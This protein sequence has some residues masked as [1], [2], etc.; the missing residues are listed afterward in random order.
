M[1]IHDHT[2]YHI[3]CL[4]IQNAT[5]HILLLWKTVTDFL[6]K[7]FLQKWNVSVS[8]AKKYLLTETP[9]AVFQTGWWFSQLLL[10]VDTWGWE[11]SGCD[12]TGWAGLLLMCGLPA[13]W[14]M[15][16]CHSVFFWSSAHLHC[17]KPRDKSISTRVLVL[18]LDLKLFLCYCCIANEVRQLDSFQ[19]LSKGWEF[20][21]SSKK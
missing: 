11:S 15:C 20:H 19:D 14:W 8:T 21:L 13:G 12:L 16:H 5:N 18:Y 3:P 7:L 10:A 4:G 6:T 2:V 1:Q 9:S 17:K